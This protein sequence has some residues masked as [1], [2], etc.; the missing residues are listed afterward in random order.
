MTEVRA[1][2]E[3]RREAELAVE[4]LVQ[5]H[6]IERDHIVVGPD[7]DDNSVGT[8]V[9]GSDNDTVLEESDADDAA[10]EGVIAVSVTVEDEET[11]ETV[12]GVFEEFGGSDITTE[13]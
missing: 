5:E 6:E 1:T 9:N 3:T 8:K 12:E 11:A 13:D 2:F 7:G 4:H 10:L